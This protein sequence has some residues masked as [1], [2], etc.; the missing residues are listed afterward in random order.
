M[1]N[2]NTRPHIATVG[3]IIVNWNSFD[4]LRRCL[5]ELRKQTYPPKSVVV[6]DNNSDNAPSTL[7]C[8]VPDNTT[9]IK[10]S[11]NTGFAAANN[12]AASHLS[13]CDWIA[14]VNPDAFL[15]SDCLQEL[16]SASVRRP[17]FTYFAA[18]TVMVEHPDYL[19]GIGDVYHISGIA[20]RRGYGRHILS[21][22]IVEDEVFAPC[23][24]MAMYSRDVWVEARGFDEDYFCYFEDVDLAFRLRLMGYRC[25]FVPTAIAYH[26]GSATSG[27]QQSDFSVYHGH[28]NLVWTYV[29]NMPGYAFW[30]FLPLHLAMN[31]VTVLWFM[32]LGRWRVIFRSKW[33]AVKGLGAIWCKRKQVQAMRRVPITDVIRLMDKRL[34]PIRRPPVPR[35]R[36]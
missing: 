8:D 21:S 22:I 3:V 1:S 35:P 31:L 25:L 29:K 32:A 9:Y 24:A 23:A 13:E 16:V 5:A 7:Q 11:K 12:L 30:L 6:V 10:L 4:C 2:N 20:W 27:G 36:A 15:A 18:K 17:E 19:D 14:L 26:I 28:R 34:L 33:D